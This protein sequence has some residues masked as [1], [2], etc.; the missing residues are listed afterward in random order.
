MYWEYDDLDGGREACDYVGDTTTTLRSDEPQYAGTATQSVESMDFVLRKKP[1]M[2]PVIARYLKSVRKL[3]K[4]ILLLLLLDTELLLKDENN[5]AVLRLLRYL[6]TRSG[7]GISEH[8]DYE[9]FSIV[10]QSRPGLEIWDRDKWVVPTSRVVVLAGDTLESITGGRVRAAL[11]R[12]P[13]VEGKRVSIAYFQ[14]LN[15]DADIGPRNLEGLTSAQ[16]RKANRTYP[17]V[18]QLEHILD[19]DAAAY[20]RKKDLGK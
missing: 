19:R 2:P 6:P 5:N 12:V 18:T 10:Y 9:L 8:T 3:A 13:R 16:K 11:H 7:V 4:S 20:R 17:R 15:D 14:P 1:D